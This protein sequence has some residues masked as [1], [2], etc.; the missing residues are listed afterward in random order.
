VIIGNFELVGDFKI[1][2]FPVILVLLVV[3]PVT[4]ITAANTKSNNTISKM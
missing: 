2:A 1:F 4:K 3:I